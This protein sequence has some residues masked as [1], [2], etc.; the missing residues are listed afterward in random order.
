MNRI[1]VQIFPAGI[2]RRERL[3]NYGTIYLSPA[4]QAEPHAAGFSSGLSEAPQAEPHAA[5]FSSGLSEA[6]QAEPQAAAGAASIFLLHP[7]RL[8]SAIVLPSFIHIQ[9]VALLSVLIILRII[10]MSTSTHFFIGI[11]TFW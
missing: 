5:G 4:P 11:V 1:I 9:S 3:F 6:P 2:S 10:F 8:E 7:N